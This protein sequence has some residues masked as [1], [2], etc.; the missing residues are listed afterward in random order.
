LSRNTI[1][2]YLRSDV[3]EVQFKVPDRASK[4]DAFSDKLSGWLKTEA[5]KPRK[6]K[7]TLK[8]LHGD[9]VALG[10]T[11]S[12]GRVAA[13]AR[14]WKAERSREQQTAGRRAFVPLVVQPGEAFQCKRPSGAIHSSGLKFH[15]I[16]A[17][18]SLLGHRLAIRSRVC[19]AHALGSTPF[20]LHV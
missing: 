12:Y 3:V 4:L 13:F 9:L 5:S 6:Q 1:R 2:K 20:I 14:D 16:S 7:R 10:F 15:G 19:L 11:G 17:S 8:Q 18:I